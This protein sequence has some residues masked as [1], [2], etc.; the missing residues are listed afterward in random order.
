MDKITLNDFYITKKRDTM[1]V[2][3]GNYLYVY[4]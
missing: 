2:S 1:N 3:L 4:L